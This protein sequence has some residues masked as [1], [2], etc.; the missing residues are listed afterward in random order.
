MKTLE[1]SLSFP[2]QSHFSEQGRVVSHAEPEHCTMLAKPGALQT[3]QQWLQG[4]EAACWLEEE[5]KAGEDS[6]TAFLAV[7]GRQ[8]LALLAVNLQ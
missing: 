3:V 7:A 2:Q 8:Q 6:T 4:I 1:V 5:Q